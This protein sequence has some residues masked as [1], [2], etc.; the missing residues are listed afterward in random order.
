MKK[1]H[2]PVAALSLLCAAIVAT[3]ASA[4]SARTWVSGVGV[5][6]APC[7]RAAPCATF[8][9]AHDQTNPSGYVNCA[10]SGDYGPLIINKSI[11][12]KCVGVVAAI[13]SPSAAT[14]IQ[15][16]AGATDIVVIDGLEIDGG[17]VASAGIVVNSGAKVFVS[18]SAIRRFQNGLV[19]QSA[20]AGGHVF[21]EGSKIIGNATGVQGAGPTITSLTNTSVLYCSS[22]SVRTISATTIIGVQTSVLND[23]PV[24]IFNP[25]GGQVISV[26]PS[27]LVTGAGAFTATIPFL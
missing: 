5:D 15:I 23:S 4:A 3:P 10:D 19:N 27:N 24:G 12:I 25:G 14:A 16:N 11:T 2:V 22:A 1:L 18:N 9:F 13:S 21:I 20:T 6:A 7:A 26:G 8:Q 17:G